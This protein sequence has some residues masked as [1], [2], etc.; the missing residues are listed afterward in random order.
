MACN[1]LRA[2]VRAGVLYVVYMTTS[3]ASY[4][5][6]ALPMP[7]GA[8]SLT[9]APIVQATNPALTTH[10]VD[11]VYVTLVAGTAA[12]VTNLFGCALAE[13]GSLSCTQQVCCTGKDAHHGRHVGHSV[14]PRPAV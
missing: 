7:S 9:R 8:S 2:A 5:P 4:L 6:V 11:S 3:G 12:S 14:F 1:G 10:A 13:T